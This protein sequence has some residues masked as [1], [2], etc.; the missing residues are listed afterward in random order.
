MKNKNYSETFE[1]CAAS[2]FRC[3][4]ESRTCRNP[5]RPDQVLR[6]KFS[7][8]GVIQSFHTI[9]AVS[10]AVLLAVLVFAAA[11]SAAA[12][13]RPGVKY[14]GGNLTLDAR[15]A[16]VG[17][18]LE[19][20]ARTAGVDVFIAKGFQTK[21]EALTL[22]FDGEPLEDAL[23]RILAG[24]SY[25]AIYEKE[26]NDFRI[27]ALKIYPEGGVSGAV[28]PLFTGGRT[29]I[30]EEKTRHGE[31]VTVLVNA[32]GEMITQGGIGKSGALAPSQSIPNPAMDPA[33]TLRK[34]WVALQLQLES[35]EAAKFS[36]LLL[37][38]KRMEGAQDPELKKSLAL[39]YADE[40]SKFYAAKKANFSKIES[41]KRI[42]QFREITGQ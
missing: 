15:K 38:Q 8:A 12:A 20:I 19:T 9:K 23:K 4:P 27:A 5:W 13:I 22:Q 37:L 1:K 21:A 36:D 14:E 6:D 26:C 25:A 39:I 35:E 16:T 7:V 41:M 42:T 32:G 33:E 2:S 18:L 31:T 28:V 17:E 24:Y 3:E 30:Y 29:P 11:G 34:P 40:M 10:L